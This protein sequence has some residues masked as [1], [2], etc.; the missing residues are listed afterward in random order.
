MTFEEAVDL[1]AMV[2]LDRAGRS[3]T[4]FKVD[5]GLDSDPNEYTFDSSFLSLKIWYRKGAGQ[6]KALDLND[7]ERYADDYEPSF[8][9]LIQQLDIVAN[10]FKEL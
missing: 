9:K 6:W 1:W 3:F 7:N 10:Y 4:E 5:F 8:G 2:E